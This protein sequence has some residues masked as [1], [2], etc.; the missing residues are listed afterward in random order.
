MSNNQS[1]QIT[2]KQIDCAMRRMSVELNKINHHINKIDE[3]LECLLELDKEQRYNDN[4]LANAII[5]RVAKIYKDQFESWQMFV[6]ND[7][8]KV[9]ELLSKYETI[10]T[11]KII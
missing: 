7:L 1:A 5:G 9:N 10:K 6:D 4:M 8:K 11:R 3:S 2:R